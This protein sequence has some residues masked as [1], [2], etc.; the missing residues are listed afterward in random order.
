MK[1]NFLQELDNIVLS[2]NVVDNFYNK[3]LKDKWFAVELDSIIPQIKM[4]EMQQQNNP[5]HKY[6][7]L[8]HILHSVEAM[9]KM[10]IEMSDRDRRMLAYVMLF[11]DIG[12]PDCHIERIKD[13]VKI[14]SFFNHNVQ[15]VEIA[16][17][18]L[19]KLGFSD[20]DVKIMLKLIYKHD[21]FMFIKEEKSSNP[22]WKVLTPEL[23]NGEI[24]DLNNVGDGFKL[25][26]FLVMVGRS[27]NYAQ[28]EKM[29]EKSLKMLE[30][31]EIIIKKLELSAT[32]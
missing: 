12:K 11:H 6:N 16:R 5:W 7:V 28:N 20:I 26:R 14:D 30:K 27:D 25:M 22:H 4:C 1:E 29:T 17:Q 31:F 2:S 32:K 21:I 13:G 10:T 19:P 8:G 24:N 15:S 23:V 9:N 18:I 3:Y